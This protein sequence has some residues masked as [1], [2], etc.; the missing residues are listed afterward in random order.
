MYK[1]IERSMIKKDSCDNIRSSCSMSKSALNSYSLGSSTSHSSQ[2]R[3]LVNVDGFATEVV[4]AADVILLN[5]EI[6]EKK[7]ENVPIDSQCLLQDLAEEL[8]QNE[9]I[10]VVY[11]LNETIKKGGAK[12]DAVDAQGKFL[13][14]PLIHIKLISKSIHC[15][16]L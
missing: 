4:T 2:E 1:N 13:V 15:F 3:N 12:C 10:R 7:L 5:I 14:L 11:F 6:G 9:T 8:A 16:F